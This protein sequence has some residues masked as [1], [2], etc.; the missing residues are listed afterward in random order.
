VSETAL[1]WQGV[2]LA[3]G[4]AAPVLQAVN[5]RVAAHEFLCIVG[6]TGCGKSTL[7]NLAAGLLAPSA[8]MIEVFGKPLTGINRRVGYLFQGDALLP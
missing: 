3:F 7:L 6:P 1:Q 2:T 8:G 4:G 5:L